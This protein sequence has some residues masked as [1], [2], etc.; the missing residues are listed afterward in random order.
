MR[1]ALISGALIIT[2]AIVVYA[3]M[4]RTS[5]PTVTIAEE[6]VRVTV[7]DSASERE[8]G[9]SGLPGLAEDEGMLFIFPEDGVYSF[10]MRDMLFSIDILWVSAAGRVVHIEHAVSPETYPASF[11]SPL[12]ARYVLELP[13]GWSKAR[14]VE[15]GS[16]VLLNG[17][18]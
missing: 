8:R 9:L 1:S 10:W 6:A 3:L 4:H 16:S 7:A 18:L 11:F 12:P 17:A 14:G 5:M 15:V 2:I 13:A